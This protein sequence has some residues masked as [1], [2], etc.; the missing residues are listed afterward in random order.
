MIPVCSFPLSN[1]FLLVSFFFTDHQQT[2]STSDAGWSLDTGISNKKQWLSRGSFTTKPYFF[3]IQQMRVLANKIAGLCWSGSWT[4][5]D[6]H[7]NRRDHAFFVCWCH[8]RRCESR[9]NHVQLCF[10][11]P[12]QTERSKTTTRFMAAKKWFGIAT[13]KMIVDPGSKNN[14]IT[15]TWHVWFRRSRFWVPGVSKVVLEQ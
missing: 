3:R 10:N 4:V 8:M 7:L 12:E 5:H 15:N 13:V 14:Q 6:F 9:L 1:S 2:A 11:I